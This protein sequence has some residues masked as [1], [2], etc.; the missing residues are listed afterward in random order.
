MLFEKIRRTQ[1]PVFIMLGVVFAISFA[2]LGVGSAANGVNPLD[3]FNSSSSAPGRS[4]TS[5]TRCTRTPRIRVPG[6]AWPGLLHQG[7]GALG[8]RRVP[9]LPHAGAEGPSA[10]IAAA[11]PARDA[12]NA[13][14]KASVYQA[15][16][17]S[18]RA[19]GG[20][21][22]SSKF[23]TGIKST[24]IASPRRRLR[25]SSRRDQSR[26]ASSTDQSVV[27][28]KKL[29]PPSPTTRTTSTR[30]AMTPRTARSTR[31]PSR[32]SRSTSRCARRD[33]D[34]ADRELL[35]QIE[36][37]AKAPQSESTSGGTSPTP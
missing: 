21:P 9:D 10:L 31:P 5:R 22:T 34:G 14:Q 30:W 15:E 18:S 35:K 28:S 25:P 1:K 23:V 37:L 19:P 36:P 2:F 6:S 11:Q 27:L 32:R 33:A 7:A 24:E 17:R 20:R 3:F 8:P 4:A 13:S 26:V 16:P 29:T 12:H